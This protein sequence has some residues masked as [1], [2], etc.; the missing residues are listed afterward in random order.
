[1]PSTG[2]VS[3][4]RGTDRRLF[5]SAARL[6]RR[7][8]FEDAETDVALE[9]L[10]QRAP[11]LAGFRGGR[12]TSASGRDFPSVGPAAALSSSTW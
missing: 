6:P 12:R 4:E 9:L 8:A 7:G 1:M 2:G 3:A 10:V 11:P 5:S